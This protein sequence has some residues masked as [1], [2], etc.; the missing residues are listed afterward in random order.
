MCKR[1][2]KASRVRDLQGEP[3]DWVGGW[4]VQSVFS[5]AV[6]NLSAGLHEILETGSREPI[7]TG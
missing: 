2:V 4:W 1:N 3:C 7:Q 6:G 5:P